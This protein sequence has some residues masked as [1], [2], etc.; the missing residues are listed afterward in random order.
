MHTFSEWPVYVDS[1]G[2]RRITAPQ[3]HLS[4]LSLP[5]HGG[6]QDSHVQRHSAWEK[7]GCC[8][9]GSL[10]V[11]VT[12]WD[13]WRCFC[14]C[15][16]LFI[17][18]FVLLAVCLFLCKPSY[19]FPFLF[20]GLFIQLAVRVSIYLYMGKSKQTTTQDSPVYVVKKQRDLVFY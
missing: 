8:K 7:R 15:I 4:R 3:S 12:R 20:I 5:L 17:C 18:L 9:S 19:F 13:V 1:S 16:S 14:L 2:A 6:L 10:R 11:M